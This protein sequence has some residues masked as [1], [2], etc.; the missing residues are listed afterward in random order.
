METMAIYTICLVIKRNI[1]MLNMF[2]F[3]QTRECVVKPLK[4]GV[5]MCCCNLCCQLKNILFVFD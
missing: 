5:S 4:K 3:N 1:L 2:I